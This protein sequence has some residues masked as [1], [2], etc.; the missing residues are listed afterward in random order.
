VLASD[1]R[2]DHIEA[3]VVSVHVTS[4]LVCVRGAGLW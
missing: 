2:G 3:C 1:Y 4:L